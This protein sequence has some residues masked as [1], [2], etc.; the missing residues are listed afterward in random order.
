L[1]AHKDKLI[2]WSNAFNALY[3]YDPV[4]D[5][6]NYRTIT[7]TLTPNEKSGTYQNDV[8]SIEAMSEVREQMAQEVSFSKLFWD[9]QNKV[10]YRFTYFNLPKIADEKVKSRV[11]LSILSEDYE[12]IGE[13]E[14]TEIFK[15]VPAVQFVKDGKMHAFLNVDDELGFIRIKIN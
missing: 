1:D 9:D 4:A 5:S 2:F 3:E 7:N 8:T 12:V 6:L 11:F 14:V 13:K 15:S 10:F